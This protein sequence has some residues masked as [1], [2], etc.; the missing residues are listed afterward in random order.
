VLPFVPFA[1]LFDMQ[2]LMS[3]LYLFFSQHAA[4]YALHL[5]YGLLTG[6]QFD[7]TG[8]CTNIPQLPQGAKAPSAAR[9]CA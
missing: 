6:W 1:V 7:S 5:A 2:A 9:R 8:A 4:V 3:F